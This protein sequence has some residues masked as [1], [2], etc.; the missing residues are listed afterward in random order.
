MVCFAETEKQAI[1][2]IHVNGKGNTVPSFLMIG[3][4][5]GEST[6]GEESANSARVTR[7][8]DSLP[9]A[10]RQKEVPYLQITVY[11]HIR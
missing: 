10:F 7:N 8:Q 4:Y 9:F 2:I 1:Q 6:K 5:T 11:L 3:I